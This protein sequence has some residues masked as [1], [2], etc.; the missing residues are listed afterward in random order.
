MKMSIKLRLQG[1][2]VATIL[3]VSLIL[4]VQ[5][6]LSINATTTENIKKYKQEVYEDH[7][8]ELKTLT[9]L[10]VNSVNAFYQR[11]SVENIQKEVSGELQA[12]MDV[13]MQRIVNE[14][15][16][17]KDTLSDAAL[18]KHIK[19][20]VNTTRYGTDGY[21]WINDMNAV[22]VDHPMKPT[23][24]GNDL[25]QVKDQNGKRLFFEMVKVCQEKGEGF[26]NYVW[27]KPGSDTAEQ[28]ISFVK[29]FA[30]WNWVIGTGAYTSDQVSKIKEQARTTVS[31]MRYGTDG[32]FWINDMNAVMVDHPMKPALNGKDLS[33]VKDQNGKRL[34]FEMVKVCQEKGDGFVNYVWP[35]PGSEKAIQKISYVKSFKPWGWVIGTGVYEE[36]MIKA[37]QPQIDAMQEQ[38]TQQINTTIIQIIISALVVVIVLAL[39]ISWLVKRTISMPIERFRDVMIQISNDHD[40]K[41]RVSTDAP[42]EICQIATAFNQLIE[43]LANLIAQVKKDSMENSAISHELSTTS[44]SVGENVERSVVIVNSTTEQATQISENILKSVKDAQESKAEILRA[45]EMLSNARDE[46]VKLTNDVQESAQAEVE[47]ANHIEILSKDTEQVKG[48]LSVISDIADQTNLLAL[49]AAIE[50][51]R[52]GEHGRGFAVVAD[53]VRKLAERTQKSLS[54]IHATINIIVQATISASEQMSTNS[55]QMNN[56]ANISSEVEEKINATTDIVNSATHKN[57]DMVNDFVKAGEN[58]KV[59]ADQIHE[60]NNIS[61]SNA[62]SV[63]EIASAA[64]HLNS[65]TESLKSKLEAFRT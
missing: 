4:T 56:L 27:P 11:T 57:D 7:K 24:N 28:K 61:T 12:Q 60:V 15:A 14:Y 30:P 22:M 38:A 51:A 29:L 64:E 54:E 35:K 45:N 16:L 32:Y 48:I 36:D 1:L 46:I 19:M 40:L 41:H 44:L 9:S 18:K 33:Q 55:K 62:R 3:L 21:F 63:E 53:E 31:Q 65:M 58:I 5:F 26:V 6:I 52:A 34:F 39:I 2:I 13:L 50:A 8:T 42:L 25:S 20:I 47:L 37:I 23:L 10:V 59:I 17:K 49:N 43:S